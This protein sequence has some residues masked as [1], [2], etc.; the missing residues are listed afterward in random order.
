MNCLHP[1]KRKYKDP[2]TGE[3][4]EV[5]VPCGHCLNCLHSYQDMWSIRLSETAKYYKQMIY[6][7]LT[8]RPE[9]MLVKID[10]TKPTKD[11]FL[12][13]TTE[14]FR[15]WKVD[16]MT[17]KFKSFQRYYPH[18]SKESYEILKKNHFKVFHLPKDVAQRWMKRG[19]EY[20]TR[21]M[22]HRPNMS[23]FLVQEYGPQTSR[24]H[25]HILVFGLDYWE[26]MHY[27]G[28]PWREEFGWTKPVYK[29]YTA[30][31]KKD[32][33]CIVRYVSKYV[34][35]GVFESPLVQDNL[36]LKPYRLISKGIGEGYLAKDFF[37]PFRNPEL[38]KWMEYHKPSEETYKLTCERLE[39]EG[40]IEKLHKY[41][42]YYNECKD[43]VSYALTNKN[44]V[45]NGFEDSTHYID[46]SSITPEV[47]E[48][49]QI[50][51]DENGFPHALPQYY[52]NK[53]FRKNNEKNIYQLEIQTLLQQS[54]R[55]H[56]NQVIQQEALALGIV[57]PD[58][59]LD[60]DS[61]DWK[62]SP[63]QAFMV[64]YNHL[65]RQ[66]NKAKIIA[67]RRYTRLT[68]IYN[69]GKMNLSN[70]ACQ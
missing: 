67:E 37:A 1:F 3:M 59:W 68:N 56:D 39:K 32:Y 50:Y 66:R 5:L 44:A 35:K 38:T 14:K 48:K 8:V 17:K 51:Y 53:L 36:Q 10:F 28:N 55:L 7:T 11:G 65:V 23:Y 33:N 54:A 27:W 64:S 34:S 20:Y 25:F 2:L 47:L 60:Q 16:V 13:G 45:E 62:L 43:N 18:I 46:V 22:G 58:E 12:Y 40:K 69:R 70:P 9:A 52:K 42:E 6:D 41:I 29:Q 57:I 15:H 24:P 19:R 63:S 4:K 30:Q 26:Y 21:D 31:T 49:I 61:S